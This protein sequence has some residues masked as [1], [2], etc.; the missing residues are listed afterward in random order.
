[1]RLALALVLGEALR[2]AE[3]ERVAVALEERDRLAVAEEDVDGEREA[4]REAETLRD[5]E[6][7]ADVLE[8]TVA[9]PL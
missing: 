3:A 8:E 9:L 5:G 7:V 1:M 4:V 2:D 6:L